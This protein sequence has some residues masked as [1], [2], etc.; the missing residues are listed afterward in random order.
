MK[1]P[2]TTTRATVPCGKFATGVWLWIMHM[3]TAPPLITSVSKIGALFP[4]GTS[5]PAT[6]APSPSRTILMPCAV[7]SQM[8]TSR[9]WRY[10][11]SSCVGATTL[12]GASCYVPPVFFFSFLFGLPLPYITTLTSS[13]G[14]PPLADIASYLFIS[15]G[16]LYL[17]P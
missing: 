9:T 3:T 5:A 4:L 1:Q 13:F 2:Q 15:L 12:G 6:T 16:Q 17:D 7:P 11:L 14:L 8:L 10:S